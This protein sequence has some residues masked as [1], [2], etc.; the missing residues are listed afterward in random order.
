MILYENLVAIKLLELQ[1]ILLAILGLCRYD[2]AFGVLTMLQSEG[3]VRL[4]G[5]FLLV[6]LRVLR[7]FSLLSHSL[8]VVLFAYLLICV[9]LVVSL[10]A[11]ALCS[12]LGFLLSLFSLLALLG[13]L[14]LLHVL[15]TPV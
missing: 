7:Q 2:E 4:Q 12:F 10:V 5:H 13:F 6:C 11:F 15:A 14:L 9:S 8:F 3:G 1:F